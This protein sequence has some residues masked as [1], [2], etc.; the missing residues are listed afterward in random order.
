M[1][2]FG[3]DDGA[4]D[5]TAGAGYR[6]RQFMVLLSILE[7]EFSSLYDTTAPEC[8]IQMAS[9]A[10]CWCDSVLLADGSRLWPVITSEY[11]TKA[12]ISRHYKFTCWQQSLNCLCLNTIKEPVSMRP[13][14]E[15]VVGGVSPL[16]DASQ[17]QRYASFDP[18][19]DGIC[20]CGPEARVYPI[21]RLCDYCPIRT[22]Q[23]DQMH[24]LEQS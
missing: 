12:D 18:A 7:A 6:H 2:G 24:F 1:F 21:L 3:Y 4:A 11:V 8:S 23:S 20:Q 13:R 10:D 5:A 17:H 19:A 9:Q 15:P 14:R 22:P 16:L